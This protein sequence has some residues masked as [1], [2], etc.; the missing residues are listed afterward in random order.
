MFI[1]PLR[2]T[3]LL[4]A[5]LLCLSACAAKPATKPAATP[6]WSMLLDTS[7]TSY[8]QQTLK[9]RDR[10]RRCSNGRAVVHHDFG[11]TYIKVEKSVETCRWSLRFETEG[12]ERRMECVVPLGSELPFSSFSVIPT[13]SELSGQPC[14]LEPSKE[15][16]SG[17][18]K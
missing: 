12:H 14:K 15:R 17:K 8:L 5:L 2:T 11:S 6:S 7:T 18:A 16:K 9:L 10:M 13:L 4:S 3:M 1:T